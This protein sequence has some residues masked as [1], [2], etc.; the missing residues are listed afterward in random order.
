VIKVPVSGT[1]SRYRVGFRGP[2]GTVIAHV[3]RRTDGTAALNERSTGNA[4]WVH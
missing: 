3:D 2:D 1:V 4:S